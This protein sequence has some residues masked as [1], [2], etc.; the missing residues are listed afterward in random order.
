MSMFWQGVAGWVTGA[1]VVE[2]LKFAYRRLLA[3]TPA[4]IMAEVYRRQWNRQ[5]KREV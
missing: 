1:V 5:R 3:A 4:V 2:I